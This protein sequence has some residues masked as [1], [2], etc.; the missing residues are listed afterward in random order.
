MDEVSCHFVSVDDGSLPGSL[1]E[2]KQ[3]FAEWSD[4]NLDRYY[5]FI[6]HISIPTLFVPVPEPEQLLRSLSSSS[7]SSETDLDGLPCVVKPSSLE[8]ELDVAINGQPCFV[9]LQRSPKDAVDKT[10]SRKAMVVD[11]LHVEIAC[12][13]NRGECVNVHSLLVALKKS[14]GAGSWG[15]SGVFQFLKNKQHS[16]GGAVW[17]RSNGFALCI[18]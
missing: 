15:K 14:F 16:D 9:K 11:A 2:Q 12:L 17:E 10:V 4:F 6:K 8:T 3:L 5:D 18:E 1:E 13:L 7:P